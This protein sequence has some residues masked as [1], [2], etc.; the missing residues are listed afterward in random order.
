MFKKGAWF[1]S[2]KTNPKWNCNGEATV[3]GFLMPKECQQAIEDKKK[4]FNENTPKDLTW[5]YH[6]Y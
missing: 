3:G 2:S 1:L 5:S 6:K 4:E